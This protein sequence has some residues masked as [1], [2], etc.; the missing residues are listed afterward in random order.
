MSKK[1]FI[2]PIFI[3][4]KGCSFDCIFCNQ[5]S[6]S[7]QTKDVTLS[8]VKETIDSYLK[9]IMDGVIPEVAFYGGSFTGIE[10]TDQTEFLECAYEYVKDGK[11]SSIRLSTRPDYINDDILKNLKKYG[12]S[13]IELGVQSL[14]DNVLRM[15]HRGHTAWDVKNAVKLIKDYGFNLGIQTMIGLPHDTKD[16]ALDTARKVIEFSPY[17]VRIYP[18]MVIRNTYLAKML[19][20]GEYKPLTLDEAVDICSDLCKLY[21]DHGIN[22]IRVG[23]QPT[24]NITDGGDVIAGPFHPAFRQLV[25]SRLFR[26]RIENEILKNDLKD[27]VDIYVDDRC[28]SLAVGQRK[29]NI[30][31]FK[32]K[33]NMR[34]VKVHAV[35]NKGYDF[36]KI[37]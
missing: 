37:E 22:V 25:D 28:V 29:S 5:R 24:D 21:Y 6:I 2:I 12:V 27:K 11:V 34:Q 17:C 14:D 15:S 20:R 30:R 32:G 8:D 10:I 23:L 9:T 4:H 18:T 1:N 35:C 3:P 7:G 26:M 36:L 33:F 19:D 13:T 31:Y 16:I